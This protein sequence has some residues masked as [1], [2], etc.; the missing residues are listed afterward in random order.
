MASATVEAVRRGEWPPEVALGAVV[1]ASA[2][3][4]FLAVRTLMLILRGRL[5]PQ[6]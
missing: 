1:I 3:I 5:L 2:V 4:A 6:E